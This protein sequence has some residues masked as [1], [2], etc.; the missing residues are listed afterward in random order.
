[1]MATPLFDRRGTDP[2][3]GSLFARP[4][5]SGRERHA[6][7]AEAQRRVSVQANCS[8]ENALALMQDRAELTSRTL[9]DIAEAVNRHTTWF[10]R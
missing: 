2:T 3:Q 8:A 10:S 9:Y 4:T 1:M 7:L 6:V 5:R